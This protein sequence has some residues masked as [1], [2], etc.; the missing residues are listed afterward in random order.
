MGFSL[1][2]LGE[3]YVSDLLAGLLLGGSSWAVAV[4]LTPSMRQVLEE[5]VS[6]S[7]SSTVVSDSARRAA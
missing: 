7:V 3:H 5:D 2:Y 4:R 6:V 1:V